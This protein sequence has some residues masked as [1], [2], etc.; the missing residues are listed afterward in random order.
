MKEHPKGYIICICTEESDYIPN[1]LHIE[2]N[3]ERMEFETDSDAAIAAERDGVKLIRGMEH[4]P[5]GLYIDTP[6]NRE[7][8]RDW[9]E[10]TLRSSQQT[11]NWPA[12]PSLGMGG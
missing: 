4:V 10:Q 11:E 7:I 6:E 12:G 8:I 3:D 1:A 5:D 2:R 9:L